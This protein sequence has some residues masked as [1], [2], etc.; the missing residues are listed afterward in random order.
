MPTGLFA[1][2]MGAAAAAAAASALADFVGASAL[3]KPA[4]ALCQHGFVARHTQITAEYIIIK[5]VFIGRTRAS[6]AIG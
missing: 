3:A 6:I 2:F 4:A 1:D 5:T